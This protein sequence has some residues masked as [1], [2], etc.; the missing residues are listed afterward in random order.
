MFGFLGLGRPS[1]PRVEEKDWFIL[2]PMNYLEHLGSP[3]NR[4]FWAISWPLG[5]CCAVPVL[6]VKPRR[7]SW[8]SC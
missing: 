1:S 4:S 3:C 7:L 2:S 5:M 8:R 6:N